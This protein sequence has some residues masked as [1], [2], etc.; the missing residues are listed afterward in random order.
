M[1]SRTAIQYINYT[2]LFVNVNVTRVKDKLDRQVRQ[3]MTFQ[4]FS[5]FLRSHKSNLLKYDTKINNILA[6]LRSN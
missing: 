1:C 3:L 4:R 5:L 2:V 6:V